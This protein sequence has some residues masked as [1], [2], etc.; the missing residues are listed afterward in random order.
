MVRIGLRIVHFSLYSRVSV[1]LW[2]NFATSSTL[3]AVANIRP[4]IKKN[5][6][7]CGDAIYTLELRVRFP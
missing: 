4:E 1:C 7:D 3:V 5:Y 6:H 2:Y